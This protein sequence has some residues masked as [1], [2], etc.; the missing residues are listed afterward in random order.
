MALIVKGVFPV[1]YRP[2]GKV[3]YTLTDPSIVQ[4]RGELISG[5]A[6]L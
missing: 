4:L 5:A 3:Q 6:W 1:T 2:T